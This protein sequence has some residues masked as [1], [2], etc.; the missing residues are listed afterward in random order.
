MM[1]SGANSKAALTRMLSL[2]AARDSGDSSR[3]TPAFTEAVNGV[4]VRR[5]VTS[6]QRRRQIELIRELDVAKGDPLRSVCC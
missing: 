4:S 5:A 3:P 6:A 1:A 2:A